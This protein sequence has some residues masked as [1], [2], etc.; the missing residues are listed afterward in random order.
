MK[1][2]RTVVVALAFLL[3]AC[4][5]GSSAPS[6]TPVDDTPQDSTATTPPS[7]EA[8]PGGVVVIAQESE[9]DVLDPHVAGGAVTYR[10]LTQIFEYLVTKDWT[11]TDVAT[12]PIM[13]GLAESWEISSD[14]LTY[15]FFLRKN[16]VFHDGTPFDAAAVQWNFDRFLN[17]EELTGGAKS[18]ADHLNPQ[19]WG[20]K[21]YVWA[22][23]GIVDAVATDDY[24]FVVRFS[25]PFGEFLSQLSEAGTG[26][27]AIMSPTAW[28]KY[29]DEIGEHP[30][31][32]GPFRFVERI[33]GDRIVL[34][35]NPDYWDSER[36][37]QADQLV[38]R[39]IPDAASRI[40]ALRAGE[41]DVVVAPP[42]DSLESLESE[43]FRIQQGDTPHIWYLSLNANEPYLQDVRVRQAI[44]MAINREGMAEFL[45]RDTVQPASS[46]I[47]RTSPANDGKST[48]YSYD[49]EAAKSL[50]A[51]AGYPD[52]FET[53]FQISVDGSGQLIPVPMAEWIQQDLAAIG[54]K[55]NLETYEWI[56]YIGVWAQGMQPGVGINQMSWGTV[57]PFFANLPF[58]STS[59]FNTGHVSI[60]ELDETLAMANQELDDDARYELYRRADEIARDS[61]WWIPIVNDQAPIV[62]SQNV[63]DL[64]HS[65]DWWWDLRDVSKRG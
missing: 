1:R 65:P 6:T 16:V 18:N 14:G 17:W 48:W 19:A 24:T 39:V 15:T 10:P 36:P 22:P 52:G 3:A 26:S 50:L 4:S 47:G 23:S 60:P 5:A 46:M 8:V 43:G 33:R 31:G 34:E 2:L 25:H 53:T 56:T 58:P 38:F 12:P 51:E 49:P 20:G 55:V 64:P 30:V 11:L 62:S 63:V 35:R 40:A 45:L 9:M 42:P 27:T 59:P 21:A 28:E 54:I 32:T 44:S 41:A 57:S 61:A 37:A 13:P 7:G 29:G